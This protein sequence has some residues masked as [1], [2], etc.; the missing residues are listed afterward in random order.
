MFISRAES[1]DP[2]DRRALES[3]RGDGAPIAAVGAHAQHALEF[4]APVAGQAE[5]DEYV[6]DPAKPVPYVP[7][8]VNFNDRESWTTWLVQDQRF[9]DGRPDVLT[10]VT[11][12]LTEPLR[13]AGVPF[14]R[15]EAT[16]AGSGQTQ[17]VAVALTSTKGASI[18]ASAG[19][20]SAR[21]SY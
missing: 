19:R 5:Y 17:R 14:D 21:P 8:P 16:S 7:R 3:L 1:L 9:V 11:E 12:P 6:S 18:E 20:A 13:I 4:D 15:F 2:G 10:F